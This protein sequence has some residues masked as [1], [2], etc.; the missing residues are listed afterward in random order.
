[1]C[2]LTF[3]GLDHREQLNVLS[4][5]GNEYDLKKVS[6][7][8][9]IQYPNCQGKPVHRRDY[10]GC[11]RG[12]APPVPTSAKLR[13]RLFSQKGKGK[14]KGKAYSMMADGDDEA[15][16][17][18]AY[19]EDEDQ[20]L[21]DDAY[22]AEAYSED[23]ALETMIQD[24]DL[25]EDPDLADAFATI[26]DRRKKNQKASGQGGKGSAQS[27]GIPFSAKGEMTLDQRA[28]AVK[29]L[30]SVTPCT[31]CGQRGH[32]SGDP[33][34]SQ[35]R[36]PGKGASK[37]KA[38][39]KK[40][41][42]SSWASY[43]V[44]QEALDF[45]DGKSAK[46]DTATA[47][48]TGNFDGSSFGAFSN[49]FE[50]GTDV[51]DSF[52]TIRVDDLCEHSTYKGGTEKRFH[53]SANGYT[54]QVICKEPECDRAVIS[55]QRKEPLQL[56]RFLV[57][58]ALCTKWGSRARSRALFQHVTK[59]RGDA[60]EEDQRRRRLEPPQAGPPQR[61]APP[62]ST[63]PWVVIPEQPAASRPGPSASASSG[64]VARIV[65]GDP[66]EQ[67]VWIYGVCLAPSLELPPFPTLADEDSDILQPLPSDGQLLDNTSPFP[68]RSFEDVASSAECSWWCAQVLTFALQINNPMRLEIYVFA[69]F[70]YGR[71]KLVRDS[72]VRLHG[73]GSDPQNKRVFH[74][75]D[76]VTTRQ[77]R[78]P[79]AMDPSR[80]DVVAEHD[81]DVMMVTEAEDQ[82][83]DT[84]TLED[85]AVTSDADPPGLAILD[86]G[87]TKTTHG[88]VWATRFEAEL[89]KLGLAFT[90]QKKKQV[91]KGVGGQI[92]SNVV[93]I[94]PIGLS[95]IHGEMCSCE[96]PG[97]L[98]LLL[99]R[100]FMKELGTVIDIG[101]GKVSFTALGV[102]DL[103]L[104]K[105]SRGHLAVNILDFD[106]AD[107]SAFTPEDDEQAW[108]LI[109][110]QG[111]PPA[112]QADDGEPDA[113]PASQAEGGND[114]GGTPRSLTPSEYDEIMRAY[115][116]D[117]PDVPEGW[118]PDDY[119]DHLDHLEI[120]RDEVDTWRTD[121]E[122]GGHLDEDVNEDMMFF[123]D[124]VS[125]NP[126][127][128]RKVTNRKAKKLGS[129][130]AA[131]D[132]DDF[133]FR[134]VLSGKLP[135]HHRPPYGK[136]WL[137][138]L[139]AGA[140]GL[141]MMAVLTG[142]AIGVPLDVRTNQWDASTSAGRRLLHND[143]KTEDPYI[144]VLT[145]PCGPWG[146]WS[147]FNLQRGGKAALTVGEARE[148]G[149]KI[150][151]FVNDT[152]VQRV[153]HK[154]HTCLHRAAP[155]QPMVGRTRALWR[156]RAS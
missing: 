34:C 9:R 111:A 40:K 114:H 146:N 44:Q 24:F 2:L 66:L 37:K 56:W 131:M 145:Q 82:A 98:P 135:V 68:G 31:A 87:C 103:D 85:D 129:L 75:S 36:K 153:K 121:R 41:P 115:S 78:I 29:F 81:C 8:L 46:L 93:K 16:D 53:R 126:S 133:T 100:P 96:A 10:L 21:D 122:T 65:R 130:S 149:R 77:L 156:P 110:D 33:E 86:S 17:E 120:L 13:P 76:M 4:S 139:F 70:L 117:Y 154:R 49:R 5:V 138:Q 64:Y 124:L 19:L 6:H 32:W 61:A 1:M 84:E 59:C 15:E 147:R 73:A 83:E 72:L 108:T 39:P 11:G 94:Y 30:K 43:F 119:A 14:G 42:A 71:L 26:L 155:W 148:Q 118:H 92:V 12:S 136:V 23:E 47:Y 89:G 102:K 67:R 90:T 113:P 116:E 140:M 144:L 60:L 132:G 48:A 123:E 106:I 142:K 112:P 38:F 51:A 20:I 57:Q 3:G 55:A 127:L 109:P 143:L 125:K 22:E 80:L 18:E 101:R 104:V 58:V 62:T 152:V 105:T 134:R 97:S 88:S 27:P 95:Q 107:L 7:A 69:F 128:L 79:V 28:R 137:K 150:L 74:P 151:R 54:R 63:A 25:S 99:S 141:S 52:M 50:L 35:S 45:S 91:F